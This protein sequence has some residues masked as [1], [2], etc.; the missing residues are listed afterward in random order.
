MKKFSLELVSPE[1][2]L[3]NK[4]VTMVTVPGSEGDYGVMAGHTPIITTLRPGVI[5]VYEADDHTVSDHFFVAGGF[6]EVTNERCTL[7]AEDAVPVAKLDRAQLSDEAK[8]L[9]DD[10]ADPAFGG[11]A[12]SEAKLVIVQA[13][14]EALGA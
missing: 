8:A 9:R 4:D 10:L 12:D 2:L 7:L 13:K 11:R 5:E 6:A 1:K 3:L 14:L